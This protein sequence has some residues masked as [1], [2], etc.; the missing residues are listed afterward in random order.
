MIRAEVVKTFMPT[1][2]PA[3]YAITASA[4]SYERA[5]AL[6][7]QWNIRTT[8]LEKGRYDFRLCA[9]HTRKIQVGRI[10]RSLGT[11]LE[12]EVPRGTVTM[13]VALNPESQMQFR[14]RR[15]GSLDLILQ[16]DTSSLDFSFLGGVELLTVAVSRDELDRR[17]LALWGKPFPCESRFGVLPF[18]GEAGRQAAC[19]QIAAVLAEALLTPGLFAADRP[20]RRFENAILEALFENLADRSNVL[21]RMDRHRAAHQAVEFLHSHRREELAM[22]DICEAVGANR[23]TLHLAFLE[24]YGVPP[25]KYLR[26]LKLCG[27]RRDL[28]KSPDSGRRVTDVAMAWGFNHLGRFS[29]YYREFFGELPSVKFAVDRS[30][31]TG[32]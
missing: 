13:A 19:L 25:M 21:G 3:G 9:L 17:A 23:R 4:D 24:L 20:G 29:A 6:S 10:L 12:G 1:L 27:A 32:R 16:E 18:L 8:Q 2:F 5:E 15:V 30:E 28:A 31:A 14:G 11:R 26:A 7:H 22:T